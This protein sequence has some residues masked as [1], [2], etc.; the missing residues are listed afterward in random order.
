MDGLAISAAIG[1]MKS[2]VE[3]C[4]IRSVYQPERARF[5][6]P[7]FA[8]G[9]R[10]LFIAPIEAAI[11]LTAFDFAYPQHPSSF[12]ML[13]RKHL[14]GGRIVSL[15]QDGWERV[16]TLEVEM[17]RSGETK[18]VLL[19]AELVGVRG[20]LVV[21]KEGR[22]LASLRSDA[23]A[24]PGNAYVPLARQDKADPAEISVDAIASVL[25]KEG[26]ALGLM[27]AIDG[28]GKDTAQGILARAHTRDGVPLAAAVREELSRM[29]S[30]AE[31][32]IGEYDPNTRTASFFPL[33]PPGEVC[34]SFAAALDR[35][36]IDDET[37]TETD[38]GQRQIRAGIER[39]IA[40]RR[41]TISRLREWL[42]DAATTD[43]LRRRA[44]LLMIYQH[45][46]PRKIS[47]VDLEDPATGDQVTIPLDPSLSGLRN[48]QVFYEKAKRLQRGRPLVVRRLRRLESEVRLLQTGLENLQ[49][50]DAVSEQTAALLH[51]L[52]KKR[53][54]TVAT[55]PRTYSIDG[56]T[57]RVGKNA[58]Q[59][60]ELLRLAC[61][62][63]L[64]MHARGV[65]GSHV[66]IRRRG[67]EEF[68][69]NV[70]LAAARL[71]ARY[72]KAR[73]ERRVEVSVAEV[74]HVRKPRGA[75]AGMVIVAQ[76][77]TLVVDTSLLED[78]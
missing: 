11:H 17:R 36:L 65:P 46:L 73:N 14:R 32:P 52:P 5:V 20:N 45:E 44:D 67:N 57:V 71:A 56:Y 18:R 76:E 1:E 27:R 66:V 23:R 78:E 21:L 22:V 3:G 51:A 63:D 72:S 15:S 64:W 70:K 68:P 49:D 75:P 7:L 41:R 40:K 4:T 26:T 31:H 42:D 35:R 16:V 24:V 59:N 25:E 28:I 10:R 29:V 58:R 43:T 34:E 74:K 8:G 48:A 38:G 62:D 39:E 47:R 54:I 77:D 6:L 12:T 30:H 19:I 60:D 50:G 13:L 53:T 69:Q 9:S 61:A 33:F 2:Q 55:A 37:A